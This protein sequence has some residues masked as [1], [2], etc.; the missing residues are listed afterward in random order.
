[1]SILTTMAAAALL[2]VIFGF[3]NRGRQP[4]DRCAGCPLRDTGSAGQ[5]CRRRCPDADGR[6][7]EGR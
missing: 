2:A 6:D 7:G 1:M 3:I 4:A 5:R